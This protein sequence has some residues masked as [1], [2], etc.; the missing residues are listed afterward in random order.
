MKKI[1]GHITKKV[2]DK[3]KEMFN[4]DR[5]DL[6]AKWDDIKVFIEYGMLTDEKFFEAAQDF[7][8]LKDSEGNFHTMEELREKTKALQTDKDGNLVVLYATDKEGQHS[9]I[10]AAKGAATKWCCWTAR[11]PHTWC[12]AWR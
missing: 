5:K 3:L 12:N 8:L 4:K 11:S 9:F 1:S 10:Q 7:N 6:E 2:A